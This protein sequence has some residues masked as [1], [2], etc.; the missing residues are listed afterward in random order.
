MWNMYA[1]VLWNMYVCMYVVIR[2]G[3]V[4]ETMDTLYYY[5]PLELDVGSF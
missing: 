2:N 1:A 4:Q 3:G 5:F